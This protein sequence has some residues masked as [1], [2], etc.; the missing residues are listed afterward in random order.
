MQRMEEE[1]TS[2]EMNLVRSYLGIGQPDEIGMT[3]Q[4]LTIYLNYNGPSGAE[5]R[6]R[7]RCGN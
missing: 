2:R 6:T 7:P 4:E 3:F 1:L 5:R